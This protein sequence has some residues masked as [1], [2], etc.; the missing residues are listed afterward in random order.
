MAKVPGN[1]V[2][3][4]IITNA[5]TNTLP[6]KAHDPTDVRDLNIENFRLFLIIM[7]CAGKEKE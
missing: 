4:Y 5:T 6:P 2:A 7:K 3:D 1:C